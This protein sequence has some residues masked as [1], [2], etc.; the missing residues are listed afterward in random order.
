VKEGALKGERKGRKAGLKA[1]EVK[2]REAERLQ[3]AAVLKAKGVAV[4]VIAEVTGLSLAKVKDL[5]AAADPRKAAPGTAVKGRA[6]KR[7]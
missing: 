3:M 2:G 7:S 1:G 5:K 6:A 4:G